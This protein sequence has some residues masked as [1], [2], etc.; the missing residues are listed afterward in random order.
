MVAIV[1][2]DEPDA[3]SLL[4]NMIDS[5]CPD[6]RVVGEADSVQ[7]GVRLLR[8]Q[9][10]D[11]VFLDIQLED[12]TG[13]DLLDFFPRPAFQV[14]FT[15]AHDAFALRAFRYHAIDYLLKPIAPNEF[16][17]AVDRLKAGLLATQTPLFQSLKMG[18]QSRKFDKIAVSTAEDISFLP[19]DQI[20]RM[21]SDGSYTTF[22][23][24][25]GEK[26]VA[27]KIIKDFEDLLPE[28]DFCRIH[29]SHIVQ[30]KYVRKFLKEDGGYALMSNGDKIP[31]S[32]RK[33]D[34]FLGRLL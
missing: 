31:V 9:T 8:E 10:A 25:G 15:T 23:M 2:D 24:N 32:R 33:K 21:E 26:V 19:L 4:R 7:S 27:S 28:T 5:F 29:Q 34:D 14:L 11:V 22:L 20:I 13:F 6:I 3:R 12:G 1:I 30:I 17:Q 16:I 18:F